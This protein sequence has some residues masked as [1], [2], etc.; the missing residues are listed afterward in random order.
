[1]SRSHHTQRGF[2]L[3]ELLVVVA[4]LGVIGSMATPNMRSWSRS[5]ALKSASASLY[6]HMQTAKVGS[7]KDNRPWRIIFN[8][9]ALV[10]YEMRNGAGNVVKTVDFRTQYGN[11]VMYGHPQG[12]NTVETATITFRPNGLSDTGFAYLTSRDTSRY[13]RIGLPL[14][15]GVVRVQVWDTGTWK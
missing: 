10:G 7:I 11:T 14:T 4:L 1:M 3:V 5:V 8:P 2:S 6:G 13:H 9:G 12:G 15:N